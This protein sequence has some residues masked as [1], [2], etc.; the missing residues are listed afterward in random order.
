MNLIML[1][2]SVH[3]KRCFF[4]SSRTMG[5]SPE[6]PTEWRKHMASAVAHVEPLNHS[7]FNISQMLHVWNIYQH[8]P[9][10][11]SNVGKY[12]IHGAYRY[13]FNHFSALTFLPCPQEF[14]PQR[15]PRRA[16]DTYHPQSQ[17]RILRPRTLLE[18]HRVGERR[19]RLFEGGEH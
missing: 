6:W 10:N 2:L 12:T 13:C 17:I 1:M 14:L 15:R 4:M 7:R 9:K 8:Y 19:L 3:C 5:W 11:H 18:L 16:R